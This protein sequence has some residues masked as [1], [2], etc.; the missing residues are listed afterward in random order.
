MSS[1]Q[2]I[3]SKPHRKLPIADERELR[4]ICAE[5]EHRRRINPLSFFKHISSQAEKWHFD[6]ATTK[7]LFGGNRELAYGTFVRMADGTSKEIEKLAV[8]DMVL[9][10]DGSKSIPS[11][12]VAIPYDDFSETVKVI[13][14][15]GLEIIGS[16]DHC[17]PI[18]YQSNSKSH[19]TKMTLAE[20]AGRK[21]KLKQFVPGG[22]QMYPQ[23]ER[24]PF[25]GL[26]LGLFL[27]DGSYGDSPSHGYPRPNFTNIDIDIL[28]L[29]KSE[30]SRSYP[31]LRCEPRPSDKSRLYISFPGGLKNKNRFIN[32]LKALGLTHRSDKKYIPDCFKYSGP[33]TRRDILR[34]MILTDGGIDRY[35]VA[36]YS[37]SLRLLNDIAEILIS[38]GGRSKV[39]KDGIPANDRQNQQYKLQFSIGFISELNIGD[40][41]RK[42][43]KHGIN[44]KL[45]RDD[46]LI[47][48]CSYEGIRKCRCLTVNHPSHTFVLANGIVTYNSGKT[49]EAAEY[50][51][52]RAQARPKQRI[53]AC[54][55]TFSDSVNIQQRKIWKLLPKNRIKYGFYDEINGFANRKV[56]LDN[57]S[58]I[59]FKSYDQGPAAFAQDDCDLIWND[60]EPP[61]DIYREQR[62]RLIDRNGEMIIS[63]TSVKGV[64]D[65]IADIFEDGDV[66]DSRYSDIVKETLPVAVEKNGIKFY[67]LWTIDNPY[68]DQDRLKYEITLMTRDEIK[69]RIHGIPVNLSGKIYLSF[70]KRIHVIPFDDAPTDNVCL[71]HVL[72]PHDRKPW[73]MKWIAFHITGTAYCVDEYPN[74][75]FNE[76]I[77]DDKTYDDY[78]S[79][80]R[81]K[82]ETLRSIYGVP[83]IKRLFDPNSGN[84]T[85]RKAERESETGKSATTI[86]KEMAS[87]GFKFHD[88][89]DDI[90]AG[91]LKVRE[92]LDYKMKDG[93]IIKQPQ[94][95]ITENC[96]N[97]IRHLSRYSRK[98][99]MTADGDVKDNAGLQEKYKDFCDLDRYFWMSGPR[100]MYGLKE[101][102]PD[103]PKVY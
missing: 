64:T 95:F 87:R 35:K 91:H 46:M 62:M 102:V 54:A 80:I 82:E 94:Y 45:R 34:G 100:Y 88:S 83:V 69:S 6:Q 16:A 47:K 93:Q 58:L 24:L 11:K 15:S 65:L 36:I 14:A 17:F 13:T 2:E 4:L 81:E 67:M 41:G 26:L 19:I 43:P 70:N 75:N 51:L 42:S 71:Y 56:K 98:D 66:L 30:I 103:A 40:L 10:W 61:F 63:M 21:Y 60:E 3:L 32:D 38:L 9:S 20:A 77:S 78:A 73:V 74:R 90:E 53:W 89:I 22:I 18:Q 39:Y 85:I 37:N 1:L 44:H 86:K 28:N 57:G 23:R 8:G 99:I 33:Q 50:T 101:F 5:L 55:E 97:S 12:V 27:G 79:I 48:S 7:G 49:E 68:I 76:M 29:F 96:Q 59:I 31:E 52:D 25:S 72:D 84:K 92:V